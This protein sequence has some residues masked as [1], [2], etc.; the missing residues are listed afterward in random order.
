MIRELYRCTLFFGTG[1]FDPAIGILMVDD[2]F[3]LYI[4]TALRQFHRGNCLDHG[5]GVRAG[6]AGAVATEYQKLPVGRLTYVAG[7]R[8]EGWR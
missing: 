7:H 8:W 6:A 4:T 2:P 5:P 1:R 3:Q